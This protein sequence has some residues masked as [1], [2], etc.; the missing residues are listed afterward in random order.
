MARTRRT[1]LPKSLWRKQQWYDS[2]LLWPGMHLQRML[3]LLFI[4]AV[5]FFFYEISLLSIYLN[6]PAIIHLS[7]QTFGIA[8]LDLLKNS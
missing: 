6:I 4:R 3:P 7:L 1:G 8:S 2:F 5:Q